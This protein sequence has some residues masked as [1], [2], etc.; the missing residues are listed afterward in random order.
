MVLESELLNQA[1]KL[2]ELS[3]P[4]PQKVVS[5]IPHGATGFAYM[6]AL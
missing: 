6:Y 2:E 1:A 5:D 4:S 3:H